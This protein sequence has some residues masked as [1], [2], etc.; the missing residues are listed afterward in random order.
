M[1][2]SRPLALLLAVVFTACD[3]CEKDWEVCIPPQ[4][5]EEPHNPPPAAKPPPE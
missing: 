4:Q 2:F 1:M 5:D 3:L